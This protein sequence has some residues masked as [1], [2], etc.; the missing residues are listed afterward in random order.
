MGLPEQSSPGPSVRHR[1]SGTIGAVSSLAGV[2]GL[3]ICSAVIVLAPLLVGGVHRPVLIALMASAA[4]GLALMALSA[5]VGSARS[6]RVGTVALV[7]LLFVLVPAVQSLP[8]PMSLRQHIDPHGTSL[9]QDNS[10]LARTAWPLSLDPSSTRPH[11]GRAAA[12]LAIFLFAFHLASGQRWRRLVPRLIGATGI[13][14]VVIGVGH[15][16]LGIG[17]IY[18]LIHHAAA[19]RAL[20]TG[21][22]VNPNH[23]A[24]LL[25]LAA[26]ACL[27]CSFQRETMLNRVGWLV[28]MLVCV[29]GV[30]ATLSR[31]AV[32]GL[33]AGILLF[34]FARFWVRDEADETRRR[35]AAGWAIVLSGLA[36]LGASAI[37]LGQLLERFHRGAISTD[38]R[39]RL[40]RDSLAVVAAHPWGIG[41]GAFDRVYPVYRTVQASSPIRFAFVENEP[42][43]MLIDCGWLPWLL[44][45]A[46]AVVIVLYVV[47]YG[48]RDRIEAALA[49]G[50][51]AIAVH[52]VVDFG[53]ETLGVLLPFSA[54]VGT[55]LG[56][57]RVPRDRLMARRLSL[58]AAALT[59]GG[60]VVGAA[61]TA[62]SSYDDFDAKL[63]VASSADQR[64]AL[65][66]RAQETH[67]VDY[68]Y[69]LAYAR[70]QPL[71]TP[72]S[73]TSPRLHALN[74]ALRLC[75]A[76][77]PVHVEIARSLWRFGL[78]PQALGEWQTAMQIEPSLFGAT[79]RE[80]LHAGASAAE[81]A[82]TVRFDPRRLIELADLLASLGRTDDAFTVLDQGD[83]LG[84][85]DGERLLTRAKL[86]I[87]AGRL[88]AA[89]ATLAAARVA[90]GQDPRLAVMEATLIVAER[91]RDGADE[92]LRL[93]DAA[94]AQHPSD[95]AIQRKRIEIVSQFARWQAA[96]R[97]IEGLKLALYQSSGGVAEAYV[98]AAR[99]NARLSRWTSAL[100]E[101]RMAL[102]EDSEDVGLWLEFGQIAEQ[103]GRDS[104]A[105]EAYGR[106]SR[107]AP[108]NPD[109][110]AGLHRISER[111]AR[112]RREANAVDTG[113]PAP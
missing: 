50:T 80:L 53:L 84:A 89:G 21:P 79:V 6:L 96:D 111:H 85:P 5:T 9:V 11:I 92:A 105:Q 99:I 76:C 14:A 20:M 82:S 39:L 26:F 28:G 101:Y 78:R 22:F 48:R 91:G 1:R 64:R 24:E 18:G 31:G 62:H 104:V 30:A 65:L 102:T 108:A 8:I 95:L 90:A 41:R 49:A 43:Q 51:S 32:L 67:P 47:R 40:W 75:P 71:A 2:A 25:E 7:P 83:A 45:L 54:M 52:S 98:A 38:V 15:R 46:G 107:L 74:R 56:R 100:G 113:A 112:L 93:L 57:L 68:Y 86:Q 10:I 69:A 60:L 70:S 13:A 4:L 103:A 3:V 42:L 73:E 27:A 16:L 23:T 17:D 44:F 66:E 37:G 110:G 109:V 34:I 59:C 33:A 81:V 36:M 87:Q 94:A 19:T 77:A 12:A 35:A 58:A 88:E 63:K 72:H 97:A 61:A 29:A 106:A 55:L